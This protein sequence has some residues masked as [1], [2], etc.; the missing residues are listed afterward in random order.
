M[1]DS[2]TTNGQRNAIGSRATKRHGNNYHIKPQTI[3]QVNANYNKA[4]RVLGFI[5]LRTSTT[6]TKR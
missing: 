1:L 6:N 2:S 4:A 5:Y 3:K